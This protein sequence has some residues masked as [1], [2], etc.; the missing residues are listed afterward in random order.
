L[1]LLWHLVIEYLRFVHC[2]AQG[3]A[4][5]N[6][7]IEAKKEGTGKEAIVFLHKKAAEISDSSQ[8]DLAK[9]VKGGQKIT[10]ELDYLVKRKWLVKKYGEI[11]VL[12]SQ[13]LRSIKVFSI[14]RGPNFGKAVVKPITEVTADMLG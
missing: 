9:V 6:Q 14:E 5:K 4:L 12:F 13:F 7:W 10:K 3:A 1:D 2:S 11:V 8:E